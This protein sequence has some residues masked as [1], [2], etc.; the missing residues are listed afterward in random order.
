M[1]ILLPKL[2]SVQGSIE[3]HSADTELAKEIQR[4]LA[5]LKIY[6]G[7]IDGIVG[8]NTIAA[9]QTFKQLEYLE[10][11]TVLGKTT[12]AALLD[13]IAQQHPNVTDEADI[14]PEETVAKKQYTGKRLILPVVGEVKG[15]QPVIEA[16]NISWNEVTKGMTRIPRSSSVVRGM[17]KVCGMAQKVRK[18]YQRRLLVTSGYRPSKPVNVNRQV[19]GVHNSRHTDEF[20]DALDFKIEGIHPLEVYADLNE[21]WDKIFDFPGG[22]GKNGSFTHLD[23]RGYRSRWNYGR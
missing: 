14:Q 9:F 21:N 18:R 16:G 17:I 7:T 4:V 12:A 8:K 23:G 22:L 2:S 11:P 6:T 1:T 3:I 5:E 15:D 19:G 10:Y 20:G 13:A